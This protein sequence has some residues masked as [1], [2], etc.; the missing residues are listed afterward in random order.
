MEVFLAILGGIILIAGFVGCFLPVLPGPPLAYLSMLIAQLGP[1]K[2]FT[3]RFLLVTAAIVIAVF[4]LDYLVPA[5]GAKRWG[6]SRAGMLGAAAGIIAGLF[7]FP[8]F[9][10]LILPLVGALFGEIINGAE[11]NKAFKAAV[12]TLLGMIF[13]IVMKVSLT[14]YIAYYYFSNL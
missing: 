7:I 10:V 4:I 14:L 2:P 11:T 3:T 9:G 1:E 12:G 8:P 6:G 5:F 13:G